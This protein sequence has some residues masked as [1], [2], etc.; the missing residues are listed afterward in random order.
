MSSSGSNLEIHPVQTRRDWRDFHRVRDQVYRH[1]AAAVRPLVSQE[2]LLLDTDRHP[3]YEHAERQVFL[4]RQQGKPVGRIVAIVDHMHQQ[5]HQDHVGWFGFFESTN[6]RE[7]AD[8]LVSTA[9]S[10]LA[11]RGC[12]LMRGPANPS[13]KGEFGVLAQG[14]E[15]GPFPIMSYTPAY[16]EDLLTQLGFVVAKSFFAYRT[17]PEI[18]E[19]LRPAW[20][21]VGRVCQRVLKR[22]PDL[23]VRHADPR[24][25]REELHRINELGNKV[26]KT[27]WGFVPLTEAELD[28]MASQLGRV[29]DPKMMV[30][31]EFE[32]RLIGYLIAVP[33][34]NWA[35][36]RTRGSSDW[37]RMLQLWLM[38][39]RIPECRIFAF[40][41]DEQ[42]RHTGVTSLLMKAMLDTVG[43][44]PHVEISW[45]AEDNDRSIRSLRR[46]L[47]LEVYKTYRLFDRP[48]RD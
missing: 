3:F 19:E 31:V 46:L 32:G 43:Y 47:P 20:E 9:E 30:I 12:D 37:L 27:V 16:Y 4:C 28:F 42:Y 7:V 21:D 1:H 39:R 48:I 22:R 2:R 14:H 44:Q 29:I 15:Y 5:Y 36:K 34:I 23:R 45:I 40:G 24:R 26:R 10:W 17:D 35:L 11:E 33:N 18:I 8:T 38:L 41:A 25:L 6:C 13:M